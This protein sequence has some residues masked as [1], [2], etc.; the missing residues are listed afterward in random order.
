MKQK[1]L[2]IGIDNFEELWKEGFYYI[3]KTMLIEELLTNWSKVSLYTRPRRFGKTLNMSMLKSFFELGTEPRLFE[4]LA[5]S[6]EE[7]LCERYMGKFPVIFLSLKGVDGPDFDI[8]YQMLCRLIR[9]EI[10]RLICRYEG[11]PLRQELEAV[12]RMVDGGQMGGVMD[13][14]RLLSEV[15]EKHLKKKTVILIDEYDVPLDKAYQ[16]GYYDRMVSLIRGLFGQALKSNEY[17]QFAVLTGC[18][19]ISRESIFTGLNNMEVLSIMD[20]RFAEYFGFTDAEVRQLLRD[21][22]LDGQ[23]EAAKEWYDGYYFGKSH[24]YCPWD[25]IN[26]AKQL[27]LTTDTEPHAY[28]INSSGNDLVKR[29][30]QLADKTT[31]KEIEKLIAGEAVEKA[32]RTDLTYNELDKSIDNLWSVLFTTGYLTRQPG[33]GEGKYRL[34]IPNREVREVFILQIQEWFKELVAAGDESVKELCRGFLEGDAEKIQNHM[35]R[36]LG[37]T[38]S[39]LDTKARDGQKENFYHG[40]LLGLLRSRADWAVLSNAESGDGFCD[41]LIEPDDPDMGIVIEVKYAADAA[42]LDQKC[43]EALAQISDRRYKEKL[44]QEGRMKILACGIAFNRKRCR[45]CL[46]CL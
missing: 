1:K 21:Y 26:Y 3:D 44:L 33:G 31:Q 20:E 42:A 32:V 27:Y 13:S 9:A 43:A 12:G 23:Y 7:G 19:R 36:I 17:L 22:D 35:T 8:A 18:L 39:I 11:G 34:V 14:L 40:L 46:T 15:F 10:S 16:H 45:V 38:I 24:V 28:W 4:G 25:V 6:R 5:I 2:P 29:F 30:V 37:R 41:I